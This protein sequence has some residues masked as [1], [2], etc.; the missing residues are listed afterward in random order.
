MDETQGKVL[1]SCKRL[2]NIAIWS[3]DQHEVTWLFE[4]SISLL[5]PGL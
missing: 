5:S 4:K 2:P 3:G 1:T